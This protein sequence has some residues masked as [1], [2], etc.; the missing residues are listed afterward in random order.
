M[1]IAFIAALLYLNSFSK[2]FSVDIVAGI[3][4]AK[5]IVVN[6]VNNPGNNFSNPVVA[7]S[8]GFVRLVG[9]AERVPTLEH[10]TPPKR[11]CA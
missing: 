11:L 5:V 2:R 1:A 3:N 9:V 7:N 8:Y 6:D 4:R 10:A